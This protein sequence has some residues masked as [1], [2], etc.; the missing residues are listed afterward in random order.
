MKKSLLLICA[1]SLFIG[2]CKSGKF[3][4]FETSKNGL[5]YKFIKH[6]SGNKAKIGDYIIC[7]NRSLTMKDS[8]LAPPANNAT[9]PVAAASR[10]GDPNELLAMLS[11]GDSVNF[12]ISIDTLIGRS[13]PLPKPFKHGDYFKVALNVKKIMTKEEFEAMAKHMNDSVME[14]RGH[15]I[16][17]YLTANH[18]NA[19]QTTEGLYYAVESPGTGAVIKDGSKVKVKYKGYFLDGK[20]FDPGNQPFD[21]V[22]GQHQVIPGWDIG[23]KLFKKGGKGRLFVPSTLGYGNQ[24]AGG[25]AIPPNA[26]LAFDVEVLDVN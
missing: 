22:V 17:N 1:V 24:G 9:I 7:S 4:G 16:T 25:G 26:N 13:G 20:V 18:I 15:E 19:K 6:G 3:A 14:A 5:M 11:A 2:A 8:L 23:M 12:L 10:K 21:F